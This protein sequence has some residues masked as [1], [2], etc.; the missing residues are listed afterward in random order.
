LTQLKRFIS[1]LWDSQERTDEE[2]LQ[3]VVRQPDSEGRGCLPPLAVLLLCVLMCGCEVWSLE[4]G[5]KQVRH[6]IEE[7]EEIRMEEAALYHLNVARRLLEEA[8]S[9]YEQAD[10]PAAEQLLD[11]SEV[12]LQWARRFHTMSGK[13]PSPNRSIPE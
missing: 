12:Q 4:R 1:I 2:M 5:I 10:F 7:A 6:G 13:A 9:Q 8:E 3:H 11:Q